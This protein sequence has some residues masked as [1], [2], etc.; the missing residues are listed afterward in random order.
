MCRILRG[1]AKADAGYG[2]RTSAEGLSNY[3]SVGV[4]AASE[5]Q[6]HPSPG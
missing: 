5:R 4:T 2:C 3:I 6:G 1:T